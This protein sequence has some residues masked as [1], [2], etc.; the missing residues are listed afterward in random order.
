M[1]KLGFLTEFQLHLEILNCLDTWGKNKLMHCIYL[2]EYKDIVFD[3]GIKVNV[4]K[5]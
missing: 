3:L 5:K 1:L 4:K 2:G